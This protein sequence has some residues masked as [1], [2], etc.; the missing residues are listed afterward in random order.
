M[1]TTN[2]Y[3]RLLGYTPW[4]AFF[5]SLF[6]FLLY[7]VVNVSVVQLVAYLVDFYKRASRARFTKEWIGLC[8]GRAFRS[9][10]STGCYY[11]DCVNTWNWYVS[12]TYYIAF[13]ANQMIFAGIEVFDRFL[14]LPVTYYDQN[15]S[16]HSFKITP[17]HAGHWCCD[18]RRQNT[19]RDG[20]TV[21]GYLGYLIQLA[22]NPSVSDR[23]SIHRVISKNSRS[24]LGKS[25]S[26]PRFNG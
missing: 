10:S 18:R 13:A 23:C 22:P 21:V 2:V 12:G 17:C 7:S 14:T 1:P 5:L 15:S 20:L 8:W 6:G 16:G 25:A 24:S 19:F 26:E 11:R 3:R 4:V 9:S